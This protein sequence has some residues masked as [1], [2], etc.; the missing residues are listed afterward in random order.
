MSEINIAVTIAGSREEQT[1]T[2][3]TKAWEL[4]KDQPEIIAARV[5]GELKDLAYV[6]ADGDDVEGVEISSPDGHNILRHS[7]AHVLAQAVQQLWP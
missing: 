7:T 5:S 4:F 2:S 3:G 6:L 1:T